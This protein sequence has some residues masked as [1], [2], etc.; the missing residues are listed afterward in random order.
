[1]KKAFTLI[2]IMLAII[3]LSILFLAINE[4][5]NN[6]KITY[7]TL[8]TLQKKEKQKELLI[9]TLYYD[10]INANSIL[11]KHS[12]KNFDEVY[13]NTKNSLYRL[14]NPYV[15]WY[16]SKKN[17]TLIRIENPKK[18]TLPKYKTFFLD[19]FNENTKLFKIYKN[20]DK[21][22]VFIDKKYFEFLGKDVKKQKEEKSLIP[23]F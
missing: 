12:S 16:V 14:I 21:F 17:N 2:E 3:I 5:I 19:K 7:K 13:I 8:T 9:K 23:T 22:L 6:L 11:I 4:V 20:K 18:I 10:L 1:M 15:I